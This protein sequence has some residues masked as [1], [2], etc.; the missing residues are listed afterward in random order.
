M[1]GG[2]GNSHH[3]EFTHLKRKGPGFP[4]DPLRWEGYFCEGGISIARRAGVVR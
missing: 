3:D 2:H 4:L 1:Q